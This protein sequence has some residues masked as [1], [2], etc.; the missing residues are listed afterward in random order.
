MPIDDEDD[1]FN[2]EFDLMDEDEF[3]DSDDDLSDIET[4]DDI[5][6]SKSDGKSESSSADDTDVERPEE[7][8]EPPKPAGRGGRRG[9][10]ANGA[11]DAAPAG[12][13]SSDDGASNGSSAADDGEP[14]AAGEDLDEYGRPNPTAN[15]VIHVYEHQKFHRT[16]ERPFTPEDAEAFATEF[17]RTGKKYGRHAVP[18]KSDAKPK[19]TI[20]KSS[21]GM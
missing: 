7:R 6:A 21:T 3:E 10:A 12:D 5:A 2:E 15:Y 4:D 8:D 9:R 14:A 20:D 13:R 18:G 16:L 1:L 11:P 17:N 19:K